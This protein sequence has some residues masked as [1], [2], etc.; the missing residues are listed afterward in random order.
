MTIELA[1]REHPLRVVMLIP[2]DLETQPFTIRTTMFARVLRRRGY[3]VEIFY[4]PWRDRRR[5]AWIR[6]VRE[7]VSEDGESHELPSM[8][9]RAHWRRLS[10]AVRRADVV[11]FQKSMP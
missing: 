3:H 5:G 4:T 1:R 7:A 8:L 11:H 2:Y 6:K 9:R 10:D